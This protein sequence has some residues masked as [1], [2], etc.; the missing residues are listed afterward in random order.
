VF[1]ING[2]KRV[3]VL[4]AGP[5]SSQCCKLKHDLKNL[6]QIAQVSL[7]ILSRFPA[8]SHLDPCNLWQVFCPLIRPLP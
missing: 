5:F 3:R 6:P 8:F 4:Y 7:N 2:R 1:W